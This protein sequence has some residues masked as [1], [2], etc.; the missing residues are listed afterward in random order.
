MVAG[1]PPVCTTAVG[2]ARVTAPANAG[3]TARVRPPDV[4]ITGR[5]TGLL[6]L[7]SYLVLP[8]E[9]DCTAVP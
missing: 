5:V 7:A 2:T 4:A 1:A 3:C 9:A 8:R 6:T